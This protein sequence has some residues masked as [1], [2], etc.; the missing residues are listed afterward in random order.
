[1]FKSS[2]KSKTKSNTPE[3]ISA[4]SKTRKNKSSPEKS[5]EK[6]PNRLTDLL[7]NELQK[8]FSELSITVERAQIQPDPKPE[9]HFDY[10]HGLTCNDPNT[11]ECFSL[12][13]YYSPDA[14][15]LVDRIRYKYAAECKL[16]G[17]D[18]LVRLTNVFKK[19]NI[20]PVQLFDVATISA[21]IDGSPTP[22]KLSI[23][24]ILLNGI[25][26]YNRYG[27][28]SDMHESE[29]ATNDKFA[30]SHIAPKL[31]KEINESF[32]GSYVVPKKTTFREFTQSVNEVRLDES[33]SPELKNRFIRAYLIIENYIVK[34]RK[35]K[36]AHYDLKLR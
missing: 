17:T 14:Y 33:V 28:L 23:Y 27:Y 36:Y 18:I 31:L 4:N 1:M 29:M 16:T 11:C 15:V 34:N 19:N 32:E 26:W 22:I 24:Q 12:K 8:V 5:A 21:V 3:K 35:I 30:N 20:K 2:K 13:V 6:S 10:I 9:Q 7:I 25:S